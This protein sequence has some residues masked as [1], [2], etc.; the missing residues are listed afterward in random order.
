MMAV[1]PNFLAVVV[2]PSDARPF[3]Q[4]LCGL[5]MVFCGFVG[6]LPMS[7]QRF[8]NRQ[9]KQLAMVSVILL[10]IGV[11]LMVSAYRYYTH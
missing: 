5:V 10:V 7:Q 6:L 2:S 4:G 3:E 9:P 8:E 1:L 11:L